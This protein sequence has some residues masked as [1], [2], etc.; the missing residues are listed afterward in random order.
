MN[1]DKYNVNEISKL[2]KK[3]VINKQV[4]L[5]LLIIVFAVSILFILINKNEKNV[6]NDMI[7]NINESLYLDTLSN[8]VLNL[9]K[10]KNQDKNIEILV[11]K[12]E[13]SKLKNIIDGN[14]NYDNFLYIGF[15]SYLTDHTESTKINNGSKKEF[16]LKDDSKPKDFSVKKILLNGYDERK[17]INE[18][19]NISAIVYV[20]QDGRYLMTSFVRYNYSYLYT[21]S[22][23]ADEDEWIE[24]VS[25]TNYIVS[26][27]YEF[28]CSDFND[29]MT[30]DN[31]FIKAY[32][33]YKLNN[34]YPNIKEDEEATHSSYEHSSN[35][36]GGASY[37]GY[38]YEERKKQ[39]SK[40][41]GNSWCYEINRRYNCVGLGYSHYSKCKCTSSC[42]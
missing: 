29:V 30:A 31:E 22:V 27:F 38:S 35:D 5:V 39:C 32:V 40:T 4:Y 20:L 26:E 36:D 13:N 3:N 34:Y 14:M 17:F 1:K 19:N 25:K 16:I 37:N 7:I 6:S 12:Y 33:E 8:D 41:W 10:Y 28:D 42:N 15:I 24:K 9:S 11:N 21:Y 2:P 23:Y 18:E